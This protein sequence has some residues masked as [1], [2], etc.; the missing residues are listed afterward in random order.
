MFLDLFFD[1][2]DLK[3]FLHI[4]KRAKLGCE[5]FSYE[6]YVSNATW[7]I[8]HWQPEE[9]GIPSRRIA[10]TRMDSRDGVLHGIHNLHQVAV[11]HL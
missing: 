8:G 1:L 4:V 11:Q 3:T 2:Y 9:L 7:Q 6:Y 10:G 5:I